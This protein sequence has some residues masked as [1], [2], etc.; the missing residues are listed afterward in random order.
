MYKSFKIFID[1]IPYHNFFGT[2]INNLTACI[3][4]KASFET[5]CTIAVVFNTTTTTINPINAIRT[6]RSATVCYTFIGVASGTCLAIWFSTSIAAAMSFTFIGFA[7]G[8][9][10]TIWFNTSVAATVCYTLVSFADGTCFTI[11]FNTS[12]AATV[13]YTFIGFA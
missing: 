7:L 3:G 13:C 6:S 2:S 1:F 4:R 5:G 9:C 10:F 12:V 11:W 8:T